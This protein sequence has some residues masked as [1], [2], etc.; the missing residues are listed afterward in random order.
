MTYRSLLVH[1]DQDGRADAR[2]AYAIA[3]ANR[4]GCHVVGAAPTG[5]VPLPAEVSLGAAA[6]LA[7]YAE[8]AWTALHHRGEAARA[9]FDAACQRAGLRSCESLSERAD[10]AQSLVRLSHCSDLVVLS[11]PDPRDAEFAVMRTLVG[12]VML[13]SARP[14]LFLPYAG[15]FDSVAARTLVA[16]DDSREAARAIS[17]ALPLLRIAEQV[18]IVTWNESFVE[19]DGPWSERQE[20]LK[21]WLG[22]QGVTAEARLKSTET[23]VAEAMLSEAADFGASLLVMGAYGHARWTERVLGGTT[24]RILESMTV[25]VLMS[26]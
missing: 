11:Q 18:R 8:A 10:K 16:W 23:D 20:S 17:D 12:D 2:V 14:T 6:S 9:R 3:V 24:R 1:L 19:D 26:H 13:Q 25:P 22:W 7:D 4:L 15:Q 5:T 21:R